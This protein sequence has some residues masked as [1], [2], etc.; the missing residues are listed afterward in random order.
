[1]L[2]LALIAVLVNEPVKKELIVLTKNTELLIPS[3]VHWEMGNA[4]SAMLKRKRITI[5]DAIQ[6]IQ[7]YNAI[8]I[9]WIEVELEEALLIAD[10]LRLYAYDA[11]LIACA[12]KKQRSV[13]HCYPWTTL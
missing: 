11:Y 12:L 7:C 3:S 13:A 8:A 9:T 5:A 4:F 2:P 10:K 1:M 6:A